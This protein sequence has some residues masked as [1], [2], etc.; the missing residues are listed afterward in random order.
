MDYEDKDGKCIRILEA[1]ESWDLSRF[2]TNPVLLWSHKSDEF[3]VGTGKDIE[4]GDFGLKM[5][6]Q[7]ASKEANPLSEQLYAALKE[8]LVRAVSVGFDVIEERW[9]EWEGKRLRVVKAK[10]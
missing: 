10:L 5:R 9:E 8:E 1:I 6:G 3:P 7:I 4:A 2:V